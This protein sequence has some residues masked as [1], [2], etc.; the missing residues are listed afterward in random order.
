MIVYRLRATGGY[1]CFSG[2]GV[3]Y[4]IR[5]FRSRAAAEMYE[6]EFRRRCSAK[7]DASGKPDLFDID[8]ETVKVVEYELEEEQNP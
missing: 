6:P 1:R 5:L 4:S 8:V 7:L 3:R 2:S